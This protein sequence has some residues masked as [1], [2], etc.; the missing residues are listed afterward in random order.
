M[1]ADYQA[2][3]DE[4]IAKTKADDYVLN[5]MVSGSLSY[6]S[7]WEKSDIDF[8]I[9]TRD[10]PYARH[11][12]FVEKDVIMEGEVVTRDYFRKGTNR[13][14]DGSIFHSYFSKSTLLVSKDDTISLYQSVNRPPVFNRHHPLGSILH[15]GI[16]WIA[17]TG[18]M[19]YNSEEIRT[20]C[21]VAASR[22]AIRPTRT[23]W[24]V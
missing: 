17:Q 15:E 23:V 14:K 10:E 20:P 19:W 11:R 12:I 18:C 2:A 7:V 9:I 5:L 4:L 21:D 24:R 6:D 3:L 22:A 16:R 1:H 13:V 8:M